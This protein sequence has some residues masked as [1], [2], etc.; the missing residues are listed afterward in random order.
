MYYFCLNNVEIEFYID[1]PT[2]K[3]QI[4]DEIIHES[5]VNNSSSGAAIIKSA[6]TPASLQTIVRFSNGSNMSLHHKISNNPHVKQCRFKFRF[7][8]ILFNALALLIIAGGLAA[9]F[10]AYPTIQFVNKTIGVPSHNSLIYGDNPAPGVCL[11]VIVKFCINHKIPY[12]FTVFPNFIGHFG[13]IDAQLELET[14][15]ALVDVKCFELVPLFLCSLFVPK[16]G[17]SGKVSYYLISYCRSQTQI[18]F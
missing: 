18:I 7:C 10:N 12:N 11:P 3:T 9:Y 17:A 2:F 16:C 8:Q 15:D 1:K 4:H 6:S 14:F 13:Q 5:D